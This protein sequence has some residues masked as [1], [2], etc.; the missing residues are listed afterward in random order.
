MLHEIGHLLGVNHVPVSG[1]IMS[2]NYMPRMIE[3]WAPVMALTDRLPPIR[4]EDSGMISDPSRLA[5]SYALD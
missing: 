2:Y 4:W 3:I 5:R 1:N